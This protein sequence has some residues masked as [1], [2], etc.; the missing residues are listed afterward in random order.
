MWKI[1]CLDLKRAIISWKFLV[2]IVLGMLVCFFTLVFCGEY[3]SDTIHKFV[4]LHD[5]GQSFLAYIVAILPFSLCF[6]SDFKHDNIKNVLGRIQLKKYVVAKNV[7]A[8]LAAIC[9]FILGKLL[10]VT[11]HSTYN[12]ICLPETLDRVPIGM[13]YTKYIREQRYWCFFLLTSLHKALYCGFLCQAVML[14]SLWIPHKAVM[15]SVPLAVF[16]IFNF[17]IASKTNVD[18]LNFS[19]VFDG[20]TSIWR[21]DMG[22]L[23]YALLVALSSYIGMYFITLYVMRKKVYCE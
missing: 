3:Q 7:V 5:R 16:Y 15:L 8:V 19:R 10:F 11:I 22:N 1:F 14:V 2:S 23:L 20:V 13:L 18:Y 6:Y 9:S 4:M 21:T 17:Y 12:P